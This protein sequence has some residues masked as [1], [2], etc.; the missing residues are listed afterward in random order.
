MKMLGLM[1][2]FLAS[3]LLAEMSSYKAPEK[4]LADGAPISHTR[5]AV[6]PTLVDYDDDGDLDL[7]LGTFDEPRLFYYE[8]IGS[9]TSPKFT[10]RGEVKQSNGSPITAGNF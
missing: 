7:M 9:K 10:S 8:N 4:L 1:T 6:S 5:G 2:I 3:T